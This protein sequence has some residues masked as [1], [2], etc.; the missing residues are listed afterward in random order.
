MLLRVRV[1]RRSYEA[2]KCFQC[3]KGEKKVFLL[4]HW[5]NEANKIFISYFLHSTLL[6]VNDKLFI[7]M[8]ER[9]SSPHSLAPMQIK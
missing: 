6:Y 3:R 1:A 7:A 9:K 4:K 2:V 5:T 8:G